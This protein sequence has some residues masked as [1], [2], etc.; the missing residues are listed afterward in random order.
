MNEAIWYR[1]SLFE[2]LSN[3]DGEVT[4]L[5]EDH[6]RFERGEISDDYSDDYIGNILSLIDMTFNDPK[7]HEK[8]IAAKELADEIVEIKKYL[9]GDYPA[10]YITD[11]WHQFTNAIS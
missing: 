9:N 1:M 4:R 8:R 5:V 2:Q 3:I 10:H 7:N 11:Y 6:E